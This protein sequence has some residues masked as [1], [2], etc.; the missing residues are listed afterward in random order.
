MHC[1]VMSIRNVLQNV[2]MGPE[3][4]RSVGRQYSYFLHRSHILLFCDVRNVRA[5]S[6]KEHKSGHVF[7]PEHLTYFVKLTWLTL[8]VESISSVPMFTG[9]FVAP[10]SVS[11]RGMRTTFGVTFFTLVDI[12]V[13]IHS[14]IHLFI[15]LSIQSIIRLFNH[16]Y[17]N[18]TEWRIYNCLSNLY[19]W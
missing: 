15:Y 7:A 9:A 3:V 14:L 11:A 16:L 10:W 17:S 2:W 1:R 12:Y 18:L 6:K 5:R 4:V 19:T 8:A 13:I